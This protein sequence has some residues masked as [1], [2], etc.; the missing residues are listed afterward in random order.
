M[1]GYG[2]LCAAM[3]RL[4]AAMGS[5]G[6]LWAAMVKTVSWSWAPQCLAASSFGR[7]W[8]AMGRNFEQKTQEVW[9][10]ACRARI[11]SLEALKTS[12]DLSFEGLEV[13]SSNLVTGSY[14][15]VSGYEF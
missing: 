4:W 3:G 11:W 5:Y 9:R 7:L 1:C 15:D 10:I 8:A 14:E 13:P 12:L 2:Q 6:L